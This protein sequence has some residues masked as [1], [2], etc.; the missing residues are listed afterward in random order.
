MQM[1]EDPATELEQ[2]NWVHTF[3]L[4]YSSIY[5]AISVKLFFFDNNAICMYHYRA[6]FDVFYITDPNQACW[7]LYVPFMEEAQF[8]NRAIYTC[9]FY[10]N[11]FSVPT[12]TE[13]KMRMEP[14]C[15]LY[16]KKE[17][18]EFAYSSVVAVN[19]HF[20]TVPIETAPSSF[21]ISLL[22]GHVSLEG[23]WANPALFYKICSGSH[24]GCLFVCLF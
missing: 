8:K 17:L 22:K 15:L 11:M 10:L 23:I 13:S 6:A 4:S 5:V 21:L 9:H 3:K 16:W 1:F 7:Y 24:S 2:S 18:S 20:C 14:C 12:T 19:R